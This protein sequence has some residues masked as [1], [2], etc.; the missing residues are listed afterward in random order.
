MD[1]TRASRA[2]RI[3]QYLREGSGGHVR[4]RGGGAVVHASAA[5][6]RS[7]DRRGARA[8]AARS[9]AAAQA[10][11]PG[12]QTHA[13]DDRSKGGRY[14]RPGLNLCWGLVAQT[15]NPIAADHR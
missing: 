1:S 6:A 9:L 2:T 10:T 13:S 4:R 14:F 8:G 5:D 12:N 3:V 15:K 7:A 11:Q